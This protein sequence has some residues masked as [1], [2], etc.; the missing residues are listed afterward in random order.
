MYIL[1]H[2][3]KQLV[4]LQGACR[5]LAG[6]AMPSP[7]PHN[8]YIL[9]VW[10]QTNAAEH[11]DQ[12]SLWVDYCHSILN[13]IVQGIQFNIV[14][15]ETGSLPRKQSRRHFRG[16]IMKAIMALVERHK[17]GQHFGKRLRPLEP[18]AKECSRDVFSVAVFRSLY[19]LH[20]LFRNVYHHVF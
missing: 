19:L 12:H 2:C 5:S 1:L 11:G 20:T 10:G 16:W 8:T 14:S 18:K 4:H 9:G 17:G 13:H 7:H 6:R 3:N 15:A